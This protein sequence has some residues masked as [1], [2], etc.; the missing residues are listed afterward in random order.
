MKETELKPCPF[1]GGDAGLYSSSICPT[2]DVVVE[3]KNCHAGTQFFNDGTSEELQKKAIESWN[4]RH[5]MSREKQIEE[6]ATKIQH[7]TASVYTDA[8]DCAESLYNAGYRKQSEG[9][10]KTEITNWVYDTKRKFCSDCGNAPF[11]DPRLG[12]YRLTNFCPHCGAKMKGGA[13]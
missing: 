4:R 11:Y 10:W 1:C 13:E 9:E 7:A 2:L 3:C 6:M 5:I 8:K 12:S